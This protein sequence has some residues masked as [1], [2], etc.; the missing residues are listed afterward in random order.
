MYRYSIYD[1]V[2]RMLENLFFNMMML[3]SRKKSFARFFL[4]SKSILKY[5][6]VSVFQKTKNKN[7]ENISLHLFGD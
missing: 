5:C 4:K 3:V 7:A 2:D 6:A 1:L